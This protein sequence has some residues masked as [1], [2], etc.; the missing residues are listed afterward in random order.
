MMEDEEVIPEVSDSPSWIKAFRQD[1]T[2]GVAVL[3]CCWFSCGVVLV[4]IAALDWYEAAICLGSI[5]ELIWDLGLNGCNDE[6]TGNWRYPWSGTHG[7][8]V[9]GY[10]PTWGCEHGPLK[11]CCGCVALGSSGILWGG[12]G[13]DCVALNVRGLWLLAIMVWVCMFGARSDEDILDDMVLL[14][15]IASLACLAANLFYDLKYSKK[16][17]VHVKSKASGIKCRKL[18]F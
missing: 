12:S 15:T 5:D 11:Y 9:F 4:A 2:A 18:Y 16:T 7:C 3:V 17:A 1:W 6:L 13:D 10:I 8:G 14:L